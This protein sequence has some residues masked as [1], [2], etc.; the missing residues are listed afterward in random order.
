MGGMKFEL[1]GKRA[2][3]LNLK[4]KFEQCWLG[5]RDLFIA[6][7]TASRVAKSSVVVLQ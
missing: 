6:E 2:T 7:L 1:W 4:V 5:F 3:C